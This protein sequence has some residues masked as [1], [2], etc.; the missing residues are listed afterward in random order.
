MKPLTVQ[1]ILAK[2]GQLCKE[3]LTQQRKFEVDR[4]QPL[5]FF[6]QSKSNGAGSFV[7]AYPPKY[8]T[9]GLCYYHSKKKDGLFSKPTELEQIKLTTGKA[10]QGR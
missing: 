5:Q 6:K 1:D 8:S 10:L 4:E 7:L 2:T 9:N 3:C